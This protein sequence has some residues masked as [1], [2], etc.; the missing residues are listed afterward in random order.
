MKLLFF[1]SILMVL[2]TV[3][4]N[5]QKRTITGQVISSSNSQP[6]AG[7]S[8][9]ISDSRQGT[10]TDDNGDFSLDIPVN[11]RVV[12]VVSSA[13]FITKEIPVTTETNLLIRLSVGA[14]QL[15][16]VVVIG[17][18]AVK[19]KDL[20]GAVA[21][22]KSDD[23]VRSNPINAEKALQGQFAGVNITKASN[24]PGQAF[25]MDIR[26]ENTITGVTEPLV[27]IDG[28]IGGRMQDI[29]PADI[30]SIDILKDASSTAIY[31]SRGANG[32]VIITTK[33]GVGGKA[34]ISLDS[35]VGAKVPGH[36]P[37]FQTAQQFYQSQYTDVILNNGTPA[38][39]SANEL[40]QINS[41]KTTDWVSE[42]TKP[43]IQTGN[44]IAVS[45]GNSGT[46]YRFSGGYLR[47]DGNIVHTSYEKY[48]LNGALDSRINNFIRVGFSAF[49]NYS[50]NPRSS[51]ETLRSAY[52][53]RPTGVVYYD[54]L[55]NPGDGYDLSQGPWNGYAVWMGIKDNQVLSPIVEAD[56]ANAQYLLKAANQMGNAFIELKLMKGL[57]FRSSF[58]AS[59]IDTRTGDYRGTYTK[60]R[61]GVNLP[62]ATY[63]TQNM[64][65]WTFDNQLSYTNSFGKHRIDATVLQSAYKHRIEDYSISA[66]NLP[67]ASLWYNLGTAG[68][69]NITGV[70]SDLI[71]NQLES[72]MGRVNYSYDDKYL[73]TV[74]GRSDGASQLANGHKW[75][76]FPSG[77]VAWRISEED[78][79]K[80]NIRALS[81]LKLRLSYGQ[82]GNAN[83]S[84][85]STQAQILNTIYSYDQT[86]GNGFAPGTLGNRDLKWERSEEFN[87]G[88]DMG[89]LNDRITGTIELYRRN[90]KNLILEENLPTSTGFDIVTANVGKI[91][92]KG[93]E[94]MVN[95]QNING[96]NFSW[97]TTVNFSRNIN[98]I[99]A[100]ANGVDA[101]IGNSLFVGKPVKSYYDYQFDGIWQTDQADLAATFGQKPGQVRVVDHTG[102]GAISSA[103]GKD[104]RVVLGTQL[105]KFT[106]GM[107]NR[108][109]Y[110]DFDLSFFMYLRNGTMFMN[111][112]FGGGTMADYTNNRYNHIVLNYWTVN[113]PTNDMYGVGISQ[114]YKNAI[115]Y[116][117]ANFLRISDITLGYTL[118]A[119]KLT[120]IGADRLRVYLQVNN[121]FVFTKY[122]GLDPE[123]NG[124][125]YIDD[126]PNIVYTF[127][128]N[129]GF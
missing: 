95:S 105:P 41:G 93:V 99:E 64:F 98:R 5:G 33:K 61:K 48:T 114:P 56:P 60:D 2:F 113:N 107:T 119:T 11:E 128:I 90:T 80:N 82:V 76:L 89:F 108:F 8:V 51:L 104:D 16:D 62:R 70:S 115:A 39:F 78:F 57:T 38:T 125:T 13:G 36:L 123:F 122:K 47:E 20:T 92:N 79:F 29:N 110:K 117:Y 75:A 46:T 94:V 25:A 81:D 58:S 19:K 102:D 120:K 66:Q 27:V 44:T 55:V 32:V 14:E 28:I 42:I 129:L 3:V 21:S 12:I 4:A 18:G 72:F 43:G 116:Q 52:R 109:T 121:P 31:G 118:P 101:I 6:V 50:E 17:Y 45:G 100:L 88:V 91:S 53:A 23:I 22:L 69:S 34:K 67:Y 71:Q 87:I 37:K 26:G 86:V 35:Y 63:A 112:L 126:V 77:A 103:T 49:I 54:D 106:I 74:T 40:E 85:Y 59:N 111:G 96:K 65:S 15:S 124:N 97:S 127:G 73:I 83:V 30:Q 24:L 7:A 1:F 9:M 10:I 84:P 68:L